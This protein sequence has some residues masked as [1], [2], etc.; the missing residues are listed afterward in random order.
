MGTALKPDQVQAFLNEMSS[1]CKKYV[2][3][4]PLDQ[5]FP[6][7]V[8]KCYG[9]SDSN[10]AECLQNALLPA[11]DLHPLGAVVR[12]IQ[13]CDK[14]WSGGCQKVRDFFKAILPKSVKSLG[15]VPKM[16]AF[17]EMETQL[18][19]S[20]RV[21]FT[22]A[23]KSKAQVWVQMCLCVRVVCLCV[24]VHWVEIWT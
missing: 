2:L 18:M 14:R 5:Q 23:D 24:C 8:G 13:D 20:Y 22:T 7:Y 12:A 1:S 10:V 9:Y 16:S 19:A 4:T 11:R 15:A 21:E 17:W 3:Q 6:A